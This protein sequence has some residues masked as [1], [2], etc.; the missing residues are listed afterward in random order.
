MAR[1][2]DKDFVTTTDSAGQTTYHCQMHFPVCAYKTDTPGA[3]VAHIKAMHTDMLTCKI[4]WIDCQGQ[5]TPDDNP[6]LGFAVH[7]GIYYPIC[8]QHKDTLD[9]AMAHHDIGCRHD[10]RTWAWAYQAFDASAK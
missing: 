7:Q 4:Q 3:L 2:I 10:A 6:A 5:P 9:R 8:A 1:R